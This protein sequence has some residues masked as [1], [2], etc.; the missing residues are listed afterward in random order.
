MAEY[1]RKY[2]PGEHRAGGLIGRL[3]SAARRCSGPTVTDDDLVRRRADDAHLRLMRAIGCASSVM[4][5]VIVQGRPLGVISF[6][7]SDGERTFGSD[8]VASP[9]SWPI[10]PRWPSTTRG[11]IARRGTARR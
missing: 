6:N 9:R 4:V 8:D 5:P 11:S 1:E 2:P 3:R 7:F 10:A